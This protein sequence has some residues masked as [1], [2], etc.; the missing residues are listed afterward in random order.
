MCQTAVMIRRPR[1]NVS[2][3]DDDTSEMQWWSRWPNLLFAAATPE[4]DGNRNKGQESQEPQQSHASLVRNTATAT[5]LAAMGGRIGTAA[6]ALNTSR[7]TAKTCP[8]RRVEAR[9][10][11]ASTSATTNGD[12]T[13]FTEAHLGTTRRITGTGSVSCDKGHPLKDHKCQGQD[14]RFRKGKHHESCAV[15]E[16]EG[17]TSKLHQRPSIT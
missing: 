2:D 5:A 6:A 8:L 11:S 7:R 9:R 3:R 16:N 4:S 13:A 15:S 17:E 14:K 12:R 10:A 1:C